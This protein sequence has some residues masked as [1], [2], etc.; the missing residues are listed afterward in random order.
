MTKQAHLKVQFDNTGP[1]SPSHCQ[2]TTACLLIIP[3]DMF[4]PT[5][6]LPQAPKHIF[7]HLHLFLKFT[8]HLW[9][10]LPNFFFFSSIF[11]FHQAFGHVSRYGWTCS[12]LPTL[13]PKPHC[14]FSSP[15]THFQ[16][17][18]PFFDHFHPFLTLFLNIDFTHS[19]SLL[20]IF[21]LF[22]VNFNCSCLNLSVTAYFLINFD[23]FWP[24]LALFIQ[25]KVPLQE[26]LI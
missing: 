8:T 24:I 13:I 21:W 23:H 5:F 19:Q 9:V 10:V 20:F 2:N 11:N 16:L 7:E 22:L 4:I 14:P 18:S 26:Y 15:T 3:L 25:F 17:T 12:W 1:L 6:N